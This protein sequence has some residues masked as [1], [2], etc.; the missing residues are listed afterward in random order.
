MRPSKV[1]Q[2]R[3]LTMNPKFASYIPGTRV[4]SRRNL[5]QYLRKYRMVYVKPD[6]GV[7]GKGVMKVWK[8][9]KG[10][11]K[12]RYKVG[13]RSRKF[14]SFP[15][16]YR[17]ILYNRRRTKRTRKYIVQRGIR[18]LKYRKRWT[19]IR[20]WVQK[21]KKNDWVVTGMVVRVSKRGKI[22]TNNHGG[23]SVTSVSKLL[24]HL[25]KSRRKRVIREITRL[26]RAIAEDMDGRF[27]L[28]RG[29]GVDIGLD[30]KYRPWII[31][32]N[33]HSPGLDVFR[34]LGNRA[35]IKRI[36]S[37]LKYRGGYLGWKDR[38]R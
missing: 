38:M 20:V 16:M 24:R 23:G 13:Y 3:R 21:N 18:L 33:T 32:V 22:I 6:V 30:R 26:S 14:S 17:S 27:T 12:F 8:Q 35:A 7:A 9:K 4:M 28:K 29:V 2:A 11:K 5:K 15:R 25:P 19:D 31:E 1:I 37:L 36:R 34:K 10:S